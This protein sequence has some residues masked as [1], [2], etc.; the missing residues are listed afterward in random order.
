MSL[1]LADRQSRPM[2]CRIASATSTFRP[3][4]H[5]R[6]SNSSLMSIAPTACIPGDRN[7]PRRVDPTRSQCNSYRY[8][9][10]LRTSHPSRRAVP[11]EPS[12]RRLANL[13]SPLKIRIHL[14]AP[15]CPNALLTSLER[16]KRAVVERRPSSIL[17]RREPIELSA[18][19]PCKSCKPWNYLSACDWLGRPAASLVTCTQMPSHPPRSYAM[20]A[21]LPRCLV[22]SMWGQQN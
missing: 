3:S 21:L 16:I 15:Q 11:P 19:C 1:S 10:P 17:N 18:L 2:K 9:P 12:C 7:K 13:H 4:Y 14:T 5:L 20:P 8:E 22:A 6:P